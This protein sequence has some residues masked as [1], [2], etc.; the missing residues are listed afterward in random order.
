MA[1]LW[2]MDLDLTLIDKQ[3]GPT[4]ADGAVNRAIADAGMQDDI[5]G[6]ISDTPEITLAEWMKRFGFTGPIVSEKGA[7]VSWL[8]G[9]FVPTGKNGIN[10]GSLGQS[11][12]DLLSKRNANSRIARINYM[13]VINWRWLEPERDL[14]VLANPYRRF[15]L[16]LHVR[17]IC[18]DT[19][20]L[21]LDDKFFGR[22]TGCLDETVECLKVS[23]RLVKDYNPDYGVAILADKDVEKHDAI[24]LLREKYRDY[25]IIA[26]GD[27]YSDLLLKG[28]VDLLCAV[29]NAC[30]ELKAVADITASSEITAGV[31]E[32]VKKVGLL[33]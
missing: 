29:G 25:R 17:R 5:V 31:V 11:F 23:D 1:N 6:L 15:S 2:L 14:V 27:G 18:S 3:Y 16:G 30:D 28:H 19:K 7:V 26:V 33:K 9:N 10:W 20:M 21:V 4:L 12:A 22:V 8:D 13:E 32:I 24:P